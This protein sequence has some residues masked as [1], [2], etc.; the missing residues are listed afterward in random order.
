ML[1]KV[2]AHFAVL[3]GAHASLSDLFSADGAHDSFNMKEMTAVID[4]SK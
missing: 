2:L 4:E 1:L 3:L